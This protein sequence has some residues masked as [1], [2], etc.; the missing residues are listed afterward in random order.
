[1]IPIDNAYDF[2]DALPPEVRSAID[3]ASRFREL[4]R[5]GGVMHPGERGTGLMF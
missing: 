1:M 2:Y 3:A 5:G 4:P